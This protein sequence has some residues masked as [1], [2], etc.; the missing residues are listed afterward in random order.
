MSLKSCENTGVNRYELQIEIDATTI[1]EAIQRAYVVNR[2]RITV[3]GFRKGKA[4]RPLIEKFYGEDYFLNEALNIVIDAKL[5]DA[6]AESKLIVVDQPQVDA[7]GVTKNEGGVLKV[8]CITK[9]VAEVEGYKGI[10]AVKIVKDITDADVDAQ[11][12]ILQ[13]KNARLISV[14]DRAAEINDEVIIDFE[15]MREGVPFEG[16]KA[17]DFALTLGSKQF[18]AGFEEQVVGHKIDEEFEI[19]VT[20][21][22]EYHM[23]ELA[24][25]PATFK[26]KL[27][28]IRTQELPEIDD[29]F[30]KDTTEFNTVDEFKENCKKQLI[31]NSA[32]MSDTQFENNVFKELLSKIKVEIPNGM[33][34]RRI[35]AL[36]MEFEQRLKQQAMTTK[37]YM[38]YTGMDE[39]AFRNTFVERAIEELK[40]RLGLERIAELE[41]LTVTDEEIDTEINNLATAYKMEVEKV[42]QVVRIED[43]K[44]DILTNKAV[45]FVHDN[46]VAI[47]PPAEEVAEEVKEEVA[48]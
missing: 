28:E 9:P 8:I 15:G 21:P 29:E 48:E 14:D 26:I 32:R 36:I 11:I 6:I 45:G 33:T 19:E 25:K 12:E 38:E 40:L 44:L 42:R 34:N 7:S 41:G 47:D 22:E 16:G 39:Y 3:P 35:D 31:E 27:K 13:K 30:I 46:A 23:E 43:L 1:E 20:F 24:G 17:D 4:T 2:N 37:M 10:N 18:I 5:G